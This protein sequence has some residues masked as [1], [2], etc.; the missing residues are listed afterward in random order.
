MLRDTMAGG[1]EGPICQSSV[2]RHD[3]DVE[4]VQDLGFDLGE[5]LHSVGD[6]GG[7]VEADAFLEFVVSQGG[8]TAGPHA[9]KI[10]RD[11]VGFL[12]AKDFGQSLA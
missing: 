12:E 4:M 8:D 2:E 9:A 3:V 5:D 1:F 11:A 7:G 6:F 10:N